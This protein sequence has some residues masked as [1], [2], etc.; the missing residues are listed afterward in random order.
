[1]KI[2]TTILVPVSAVVSSVLLLLAGKMRIFELLAVIASGIWLALTL[3]LF[4]WPIH[5]AGSMGLIIGGT[6]MVAGIFV[7]LNTSNKR[8]VT[9]STV[10]TIL[11]GVLVVGALAQI[12]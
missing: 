5:Q 6:L 1:M 10:I 2:D 8:E 12:T 9:A 11:G 3:G 7:Y 4:N